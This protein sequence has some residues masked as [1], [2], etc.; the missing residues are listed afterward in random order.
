MDNHEMWKKVIEEEQEERRKV[1]PES[2]DQS[3]LLQSSE[4]IQ[5][6]TEEEEE[7]KEEKNSEGSQRKSVPLSSITTLTQDT[8]EG[9]KNDWPAVLTF[10][11]FLFPAHSDT[12]L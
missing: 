12:I 9:D 10:I 5:A 7:E 2:P 1:E 4:T 8:L 3:S 11:L 6:I